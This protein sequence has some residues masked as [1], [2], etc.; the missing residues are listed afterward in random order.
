MF[1]DF[2]AKFVLLQVILFV[3]F[4]SFRRHMSCIK[5]RMT[6]DDLKKVQNLMRYLRV[7]EE[8]EASVIL[9]YILQNHCLIVAQPMSDVSL[10]MILLITNYSYS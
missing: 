1:E 7:E 3:P 9:L 8:N 6:L 4:P 2:E 10:I 5:P